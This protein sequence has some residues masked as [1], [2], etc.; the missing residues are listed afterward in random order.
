[1][2]IRR[3]TPR[4]SCSPITRAVHSRWRAARRTTSSPTASRR[5]WTGP[6]RPPEIARSRSR[7]ARAPSTSTSPPA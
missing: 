5:H 3:T 7:A 2:R 4:F 1:V 6:V